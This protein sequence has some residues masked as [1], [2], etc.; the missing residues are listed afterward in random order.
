MRLN[1]M[2]VYMFELISLSL[3]KEQTRGKKTLKKKTHPFCF[4]IY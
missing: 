3:I 4:E 1:R 2:E